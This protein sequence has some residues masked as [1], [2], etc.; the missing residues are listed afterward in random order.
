MK[1]S[2]KNI[3]IIALAITLASAYVFLGQSK[4][5]TPTYDFLSVKRGDI[6]QEVNSSGFVKPAKKVDLAF[7]KAGK[8]SEINVSVGGSVT[9]GQVL[10]SLDGSDISSQLLQAQSSVLN[11]QALLIQ[12]E[13]SYD[14]QQAKLIDL[15][16][17]TRTEE[18]TLA[19]TNVNNAQETVSNAETNLANTKISNE[20]GLNQAYNNALDSVNSSLATASSALNTNETTLNYE[21]AK[22]TLSVLNLQYLDNSRTSRLIAENS[23]ETAKNFTDSMDANA[24]H[25]YIDDSLTKT[26]KALE[27]GR[28]ALIDTNNVLQATITSSKLSQTELDTLKANIY[29]A[30]TS[31]NSAISNLTS[32]T[33]SIA[34]QNISDQNNIS[35]A[36]MKV[37]DAKNALAVAEDALALKKSGP[38]KEQIDAQE[39]LVRQAQ[40]GIEAQ[41]AQINSAAANVT[42]IKSQLAKMSL[43][44]PIDGIVTQ[45]NIEVGETVSPNLPLISI[46]SK[47]KFQIETMISEAEIAKIKVGDPAKITLDAFGNDNVFDA[48]II[49]IDPA[50]IMSEGTPTYKVTLEFEKE[51]S[52]IKSGLTANI[53]IISEKHE[54]VIIVPQ[55]AIITKNNEKFVLVKNGDQLEE[56]KIQTGIRGSDGNIEII[57]GL[58][59]TD[60][61][62]NFGTNN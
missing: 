51:Y 20:N 25:K 22:D 18:I 12:A 38:T 41:K 31:I 56:R 55:R 58:N 53:D 46:F 3:I 33:Q 52:E 42:I 59:E 8:I 50:E 44:S 35:S 10:A 34:T 32:S 11:A 27:D 9:T 39:A 30:R 54:N 49:S 15:K 29:S 14:S 5:K 19:Q 40:A 43:L 37:S 1:K 17:G 13:A 4:G 47:N 60:S 24:D 57:S 21:D 7:E 16:N 26:K 61:I 6:I 45:M 62:A 23:Y 28:I 2:T 36:E 48:K